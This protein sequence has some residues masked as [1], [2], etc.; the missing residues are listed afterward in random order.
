MDQIRN[1]IRRFTAP[2]QPIPAGTYAYQSPPDAENQY[3]L[4][5]RLEPGGD[6]ILVVNA[7]TVLHLNQTAAEYAW[8]MVKGSTEEQA[9]EMVSARYH[10]DFTQAIRDFRDFKE[11]ILTLVHTPDVDP[12][13]SLEF[14]RA[15]P[16]SRELSAPLRLD[17]AITYRT[18]SGY[19]P[20]IAPM[21]HVRREMSTEE[22]KTA[23]GKAW[24]AG[25]PHIVFTG[26]E[27]TLRPDLPELVAFCEEQGIVTGLLTD[28]LR[29]CEK[30]FLHAL[31]QAG[32]DHLLITLDPEEE[33]AWECIR[34]VL[35][36]DIYL[37]VHLT[38][39]PGNAADLNTNLEKLA[40][41]GVKAISLSAGKEGLE[42]A[43]AAAR[44]RAAEL[45]LSLVWDV[46]V[47][48]SAR[49]PVALELPEN[50]P[51]GAGKAWMYVEP[52]GDVLPCQGA[53]VV[54]GCLLEDSWE[55]IAAAAKA[56]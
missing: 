51:D 27:A 50:T 2:S 34:D 17:C 32:L 23:I 46:A 56:A 22:W 18:S 16:Y 21:D 49:H 44:Q 31:L 6:G 42:E 48:Y 43:L 1:F 55:K 15:L 8:H 14:D 36:E 41:M 54:L 53:G 40:N 24:D 37:A 3:R 29:L 19:D 30:N 52:D 20:R 38:I 47:P 28:G 12:E 5:L 4:H 10:V 7:S 11:R 35:P 39:L 45:K 9:G 25:I 33:T 26:G 13:L